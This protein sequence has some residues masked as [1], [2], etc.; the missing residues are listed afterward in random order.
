MK[1]DE[2]EKLAKAVKSYEVRYFGIEQAETVLKLIAVAWAAERVEV[3]GMNGQAGLVLSEAIAAL[4]DH[5]ES[6]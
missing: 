1:L 3:E 6:N 5:N 4:E 2:L